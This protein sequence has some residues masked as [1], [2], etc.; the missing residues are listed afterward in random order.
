MKSLT[1]F[2]PR[3]SAISHDRQDDI[4]GS[5][6]FERSMQLI[7]SIL[8]VLFCGIYVPTDPPHPEERIVLSK[9]IVIVKSLYRQ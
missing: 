3:I 8:G 5:V 7:I 9:K 6:K 1:E 2:R 4:I